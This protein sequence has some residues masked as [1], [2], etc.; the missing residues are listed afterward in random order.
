MSDNNDW[1]MKGGFYF[2]ATVLDARATL[3]VSLTDTVKLER[4]TPEQVA[5]IKEELDRPSRFGAVSVEWYETSWSAKPGERPEVTHYD[6]T[7][8]APEAYRYFVLTFSGYNS[9]A[10]DVLTVAQVVE[11]FMGAHI[12]FLTDEAFGRGKLLGWG[13][14][15]IGGSAFYLPGAHTCALLQDSNIAQLREAFSKYKALDKQRHEGILR[16]FG[17]YQNLWRLSRLNELPILGLFAVIEMLLTH[18]PNDKEIGDSLTHQIK[19]KMRLLEPRFSVQLDYTNFASRNP[20]SVW[21]ALYAY[22]SSIAHGN[23]VAFEGRLNLLVD[24]E[25]A[26]SFLV[27]ATRALLLHSL[28]EP[29]LVNSLKPI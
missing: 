9:E 2:I 28:S 27:S 22:R 17:Y 10:H 6:R 8:L 11:P 26:F 7:L 14:D 23:H 4:A 24:R 18:N 5:A 15:T 29:D 19:T 3:P 20:D 25:H 13:G 16:A 21:G 1:P 12:N